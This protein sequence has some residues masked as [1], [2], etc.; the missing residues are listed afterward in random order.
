MQNYKI[1]TYKPQKMPAKFAIKLAKITIKF[2]YF[3]ILCF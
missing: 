3:A 1:K 2:A